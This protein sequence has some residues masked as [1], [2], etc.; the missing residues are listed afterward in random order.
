MQQV[1]Q[2]VRSTHA[3]VVDENLAG[4]RDCRNFIEDL[5][6]YAIELPDLRSGKP[7]ARPDQ[8]VK[9]YRQFL[10]HFH[11]AQEQE[12]YT[13]ANRFLNDQVRG[14]VLNILKV[15]ADDPFTLSDGDLL[16]A[17]NETAISAGAQSVQPIQKVV[18]TTS[19]ATAV[20]YVFVVAT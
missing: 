20:N 8:G 11:K 19:G 10:A 6:F 4:L 2:I 1:H 7:V 15:A 13:S 9:N 12:L 14:D 5:R 3:I 16:A 17:A 18:L